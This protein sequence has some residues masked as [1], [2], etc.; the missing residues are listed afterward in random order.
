MEK[1]KNN[2]NEEFSS[3]VEDEDGGY[4]QAS[5]FSKAEVT[6]FQIQKILEIRSREMTPGYYNASVSNSGEEVRTWIPDSRKAFISSIKALK[7]LLFPEVVSEETIKSK[8]IKL[9]EREEKIFEENCYHEKNQKGDKLEETG[10]KFIPEI[11]HY[12]HVN[13]TARDGVRSIE[14]VKGIWNDKVSLYWD[15]MVELYDEV[16]AELNQLIHNLSY[17]DPEKVDY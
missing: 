11:D 7:S 9:E 5:K 1:N 14:R 6:R 12:I 13:S 17:F 3:T 10:K 16:F 2:L 15:E 8:L 4:T